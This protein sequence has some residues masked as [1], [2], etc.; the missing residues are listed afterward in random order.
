M[1]GCNYTEGR[2]T[3]PLANSRVKSNKCKLQLQNLDNVV[4]QRMDRSLVDSRHM[5]V[6]KEVVKIFFL[7]MVHDENT[8]YRTLASGQGLARMHIFCQSQLQVPVIRT[9][10]ERAA[11]DG[12]SVFFRLI[13][14]M[15]NWL[16][17]RTDVGHQVQCRLLAQLSKKKPFIFHTYR[18]MVLA[19]I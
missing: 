15:Q 11:V 12:T 17:K 3:I 10:R 1:T 5:N 9:W 19:N 6:F 2:N 16:K 8:I 7:G 14:I 13:H 4:K 18:C